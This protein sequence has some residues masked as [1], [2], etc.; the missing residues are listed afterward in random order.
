[1]SIKYF[2]A[3]SVPSLVVLY[4][5]GGNKYEDVLGR[6]EAEGCGGQYGSSKWKVLREG[7]S[8]EVAFEN[9]RNQLCQEPG[10][11]IAARSQNKNKGAGAGKGLGDPEMGKRPWDCS[12]GA[13]GGVRT[14]KEGRESNGQEEGTARRPTNQPCR[15]RKTATDGFDILH[16]CIL[17]STYKSSC[18]DL[19]DSPGTL[20]VHL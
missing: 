15:C 7:F 12:T 18:G 10:R 19:Q 16:I 4:S 6:K 2:R 11:S 14:P 5:S 20:R 9:M 17:Q 13:G 3:L 1:M 8:Q